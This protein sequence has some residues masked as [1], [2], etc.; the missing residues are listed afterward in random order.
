MYFLLVTFGRAKFIST[1]ST[2]IV[3]GMD[4]NELT[5]SS[6]AKSHTIKPKSKVISEKKHILTL[7]NT[8]IIL[9]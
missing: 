1:T 4:M 2:T 9:R 5:I 7:T 6:I 8:Q 3:E